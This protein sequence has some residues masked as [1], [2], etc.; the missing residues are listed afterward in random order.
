MSSLIPP[1]IL[2]GVDAARQLEQSEL[3]EAARIEAV[4]VIAKTATGSD[5]IDQVFSLNLH[6]RLVLVRCHFVGGTGRSEMYLEVDS[7]QGSAYDTGLFTVRVAGVG[8]DVNFRLTA[9]ETR[10]PSAWAL[11]PGDAFRIK[12]TNPDPGNT[13]WGL[14]VGLAPA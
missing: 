12:W 4:R 7:A 14:E 8:A 10:L 9:E 2:A 3:A 11:Q 5:D 13:T 1:N 6:F